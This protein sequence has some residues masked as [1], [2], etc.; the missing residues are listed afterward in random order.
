MTILISSFLVLLATVVTGVYIAYRLCN[1]TKLVVRL[2]L[3][4]PMCSA[5][6]S[7]N[8]MLANDYIPSVFSLLRESSILVLYV[9]IAILL[10]GKRLLKNIDSICEREIT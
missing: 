6:F 4:L 7:L 5:V 9:L 2:I 10:K 1:D 3:L 8:L